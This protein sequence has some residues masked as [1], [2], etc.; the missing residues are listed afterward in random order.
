[1]FKIY[2]NKAFLL[3]H[4]NEYLKPMIKNPTPF[5]WMILYSSHDSNIKVFFFWK[6]F[7]NILLRSLLVLEMVL[8]KKCV[9]HEF[10]N[11]LPFYVLI[12]SISIKS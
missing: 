10:R 12:S 9:T 2:E 5:F 3:H 4:R 11:F 7:S 1:M 8:T 6:I